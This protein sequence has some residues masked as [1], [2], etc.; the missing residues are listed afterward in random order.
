[1]QGGASDDCRPKLHRWPFSVL[2]SVPSST[3]LRAS[4]AFLSYGEQKRRLPTPPGTGAHRRVPAGQA[5]V[6]AV[7]QDRR[8]RMLRLPRS[9]CQAV[10]QV[11]RTSAAPRQQGFFRAPGAWRP[12]VSYTKLFPVSASTWKVRAARREHEPLGAWSRCAAPRDASAPYPSR[13]W[14]VFAPVCPDKTPRLWCPAAQAAPGLAVR[15]AMA[16]RCHAGTRDRWQGAMRRRPWT[17]RS[18]TR[19]EERSYYIGPPA[20]I[21]GFFTVRRVPWIMLWTVFFVFIN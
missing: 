11:Y 19:G 17:S 4:P 10:S 5:R 21:T 1:V 6:H 12:T 3:P 14:R 2:Y 20:T 16:R 13:G 7:R 15:A 8:S 18:G 9:A